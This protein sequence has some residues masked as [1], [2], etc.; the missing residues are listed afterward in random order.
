MSRIWTSFSAWF[1]RTALLPF[2]PKWRSAKL[3]TVEW[4]LSP[5]VREQLTLRWIPKKHPTKSDFSWN[6]AMKQMLVYSAADRTFL[7]LAVRLSCY[8]SLSQRFAR[9]W[10][11]STS[12]SMDAASLCSKSAGTTSCLTS[13]FQLMWIKSTHKYVVVRLYRYGSP[14]VSQLFVSLTEGTC[15]F[16][17]VPRC[18]V[19]V[20]SDCKMYVRLIY[21]GSDRNMMHNAPRRH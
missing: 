19:A 16:A 12:P 21:A 9:S 20:H 11:L 15:F 13:T 4:N 8:W 14:N 1:K 18:F 17:R 5:I 3:P 6:L 10:Q 2:A 7:H